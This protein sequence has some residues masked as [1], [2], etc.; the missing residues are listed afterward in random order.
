[1]QQTYVQEIA[2]TTGIPNTR[3]KNN[4]TGES[5]LKTREVSIATVN[6]HCMPY[7]AIY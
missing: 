1:M 3:Q 7:D 5:H 6:C 2:Y 4:Y